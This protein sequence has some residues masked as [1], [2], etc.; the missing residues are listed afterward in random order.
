[1]VEWSTTQPPTRYIKPVSEAE[2]STSHIVPATPLTDP[3]SR[4]LSNI[5]TQP[6]T[7]FH[8]SI[9][10]STLPVQ[11]EQ[12]EHRTASVQRLPLKLSMTLKFWIQ[13]QQRHTFLQRLDRTTKLHNL[14]ARSH[15]VCTQLRKTKLRHFQL[16]AAMTLGLAA[17]SNHLVELRR[18]HSSQGRP[19]LAVRSA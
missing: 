8:G 17:P 7:L 3:T 10:S 9:I 19:H 4:L 16:R 5:K 14:M 2:S 15:P 13:N 12:V 11:K 1:M 18:P 6:G